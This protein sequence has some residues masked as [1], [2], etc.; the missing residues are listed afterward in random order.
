MWLE[1]I[2]ATGCDAVGLDWTVDIRHARQRVG[3]KVALQGN[4]DPSILL[5]TPERI[6]LEVQATVVSTMPDRNTAN[7]TALE[8]SSVSQAADLSIAKTIPNASP[9][10]AGQVYTYTL[11]PR[12]VVGET[13]GALISVTDPLP[14][15]IQV[16]TLPTVTNSAGLWNCS[17]SPAQSLPFVVSA[18]NPVQLLCTSTTS[19]QN[20]DLASLKLADIQ[21]SFVPQVG[22]T[23]INTSNVTINGVS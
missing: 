5:G 15:D 18:S 10:G 17:Y 21:F 2:A 4:M 16:T 7:N 9:L 1:D 19:Y 13:M 8:S 6:R 23:L 14:N 20:S 12:L 11:T 22:G 3:D